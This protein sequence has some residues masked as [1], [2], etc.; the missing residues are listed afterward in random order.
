MPAAVEMKL[1]WFIP[2]EAFVPGVQKPVKI[3]PPQ[4]TS[5]GLANLDAFTNLTELH[6]SNEKLTDADLEPLGKLTGLKKLGVFAP[7]VTNKGVASLKDLKKLEMI[8]LRGTKITIGAA[9]TLR[10]MPQLKLLKNNLINWDP[11]Y[12]TKL[13]EW[14]KQLPRVKVE[15]LF[16]MLGG[17]FGGP[18]LGGGGG[19]RLK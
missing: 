19:G 3:D 4:W 6:V 10:G 1:E 8:D 16:S 11:K 2:K 14:R 17:V 5:K 18:G 13:A 15:P 9:A 12:K 7:E